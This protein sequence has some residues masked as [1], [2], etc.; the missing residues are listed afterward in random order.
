MSR[1]RGA[2]LFLAAAAA[3]V[4]ILALAASPSSLP[5]H[6]Y[7]TRIVRTKYGPVRGVVLLQQRPR[8]AVEAFL[9]VP[10]A[11][12]PLGSLRYM[13]PVT[14]SSWRGPRL[15]DTFSAVC[16]QR[17]PDIANRS[18]ALLRLPRGRLRH[19]ERLLPLLANQSEDCLYL[20]IYV[21]RAGEYT[22]LHVP[23]TYLFL[24]VT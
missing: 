13:P 5:V 11:T 20:N 6:K 22:T 21:P 24:S 17:T 16:P 3:T 1:R 14:P 4:S 18:E 15:A 23:H 8:I 12:P 9:G 2:P 19:L 7:S 10:Y